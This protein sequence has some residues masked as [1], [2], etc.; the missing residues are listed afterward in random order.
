MCSSPR[1][2]QSANDI[3]NTARLAALTAVVVDMTL[4]LEVNNWRTAAADRPESPM[5][6]T[7]QLG[8]P[9]SPRSEVAAATTISSGIKVVNPR[10]ANPK[11]RCM[12]SFR[13]P[14]RH[15]RPSLVLD[16]RF[17]QAGCG[18]DLCE[19]MS[20]PFLRSS[21]PTAD[22]RNG[23]QRATA[24]A[25]PRNVDY[26]C[27]LAGWK[28][29]IESDMKIIYS[30]RCATRGGDAVIDSRRRPAGVAVEAFAEQAAA[31]A[32]GVVDEVPAGADVVGWSSGRSIGELRDRARAAGHGRARRLRRQ[33]TP[34][35]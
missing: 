19:L 1:F 22:R 13:V 3:P 6:P 24:A 26:H 29:D 28:C 18:R 7:T 5:P 12:I 23:D 15:M 25:E 21:A 20:A 4:P 31:T 30:R 33:P 27:G 8:K 2:T 9:P 14:A 16:H 32:R 34:D 10:A 35:R 17:S 11:D